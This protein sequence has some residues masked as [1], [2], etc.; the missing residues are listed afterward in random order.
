MLI[1]LILT[2][3]DKIPHILRAFVKRILHGGFLFIVQRFVHA[4]EK[5]T[6]SGERLIGCIVF[7]NVHWIFLFYR[8]EPAPPGI[9]LYLFG[10]H[11]LNSVI[12]FGLQ[13]GQ[14]KKF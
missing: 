13:T 2:S 14:I 11:L 3:Y 10:S 8:R 4:V 5:L 9:Y 12:Y 7:G 1:V 6:S